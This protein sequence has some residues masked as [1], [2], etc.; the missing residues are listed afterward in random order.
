[1]DQQINRLPIVVESM[2]IGGWI[3]QLT[4]ENSVLGL[5]KD[6]LETKELF[7]IKQRTEEPY[8]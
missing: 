8:S 2:E 4:T 6:C 5:S 7:G 1:M 3:D